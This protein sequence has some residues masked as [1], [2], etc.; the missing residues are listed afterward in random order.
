MYISH[1]FAKGVKNH[2]SRTIPNLG[3]LGSVR[4]FVGQVLVAIFFYLAT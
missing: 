3:I 1:H 4:F 2:G